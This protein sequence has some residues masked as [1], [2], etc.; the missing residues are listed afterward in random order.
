MPK[1]PRRFADNRAIPTIGIA[2][3]AAMGRRALMRNGAGL[4]AAGAAL[5]V[6]PGTMTGAR[7]AD[8]VS[9]VLNWV[10]SVQFGGHFA[11]L[12]NGFFAEND[13]EAEFISGG[14]GID[15]INLVAAGESM[16]GDRDSTNLILARAKGIPV[17]AFAAALQ[18]SP[19]AMMSLAESPVRS[20]EDMQGK[21]I[22][23][24]SQRRPTM[25][26]LMRGA[27]LDPDSVTFVPTGT[28]PGILPTGQV[29]AYFG[30][31]TNQG[32]MLQMRGVDLEIVTLDELG[33]LTYPMVFF[34]TEETL[35]EKAD[36]VTRWLK[37]E[38]AAWTWFAENP[39]ET[40]RVTVE[41]YGQQ[42]L[43]L[44]QQITE[45]R[46]YPD[47]IMAGDA[48]EKGALWIG[49]EKFEA[50][51]K[52]AVDAGILEEAIDIEALVDQSFITAAHA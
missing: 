1:D 40:A 52:L 47:Y 49:P 17:K 43:D 18:K 46:T 45:S 4:L 15:S 44:E 51:M 33:D 26:A 39:E 12:H 20:L 31:A 28:D 30:W 9:L 14:P 19:Y 25:V 7:A 35:G 41:T 37:A 24:P 3:S 16:L 5:G 29:D 42:G 13:I 50:G 27:G 21:T 36:V 34:A 8:P 11:G 23:I 38:I 48:L 6:L 32:V 22:A 2:G 10:K